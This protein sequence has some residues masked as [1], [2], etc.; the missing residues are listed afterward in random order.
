MVASDTNAV[1]ELRADVLSAQQQSATASADALRARATYLP[2]INSFARYDWNAANRPYAGQRNWTVGVMAS[3]NPFGSATELSDIRATA[4]R[5]SAA[6]AQAEAAA[7][8]ASLDVAQTRVALAVA[9]TRLR[10]AE[11]AVAQSAEAQRIVSRKYQGG[12]ASIVDLLDAQAVE[13]R[14]ALALSDAR[15]RVIVAA[16]ERRRALGGDPATLAALDSDV[17]AP[18]TAISAA[19]ASITSATGSHAQLPR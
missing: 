17:T 1:V 14:S 13:T 18:A 16:A 11:Q 4:G 15:Y 3:W 9:L 7:A 2:R 5:A 8:E 10:I 6:R 12:L 19:G